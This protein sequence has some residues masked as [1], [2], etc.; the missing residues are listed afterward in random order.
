MVNYANGKI[1]MIRPIV[2]H[3]E[4]EVYIGSTTKFYLSD[5]MFC[6]RNMYEAYNDGQYSSRY[7]VFDLFDKYGAR[8][9]DIYLIEEVCCNSKAEL[10]AREGFHIRNTKCVNKIL[11]GGH[12]REEILEKKK[13]YRIDNKEKIKEYSEKRKQKVECPCGGR[14][15]LDHKNS[16]MK[17]KKHIAFVNN[18]EA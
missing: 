15:T 9:C 18:N 8:N 7:S 14:Y 12:T 6:H 2:D 4:G 5:R 13:Q 10:H 16:H 11:A 17:T 3:E 1:Y